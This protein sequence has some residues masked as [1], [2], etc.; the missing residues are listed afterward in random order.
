MVVARPAGIYLIG[1]EEQHTAQGKKNAQDTQTEKLGAVDLES[2]LS[3]KQ[4]DTENQTR[5][6]I[7]ERKH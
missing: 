5:N 1:K 2:L 7:T 4:P 6:Q 3:E